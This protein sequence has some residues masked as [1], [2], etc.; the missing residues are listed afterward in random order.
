MWW[1]S[2]NKILI[3]L[4]RISVVKVKKKKKIVIKN[5][6]RC[7]R[8]YSK[9]AGT[10][11]LEF[12]FTKIIFFKL[13]E[14]KRLSLFLDFELNRVLKKYLGKIVFQPMH[15]H[16]LVSTI[17]WRYTR[18]VWKNTVFKRNVNKILINLCLVVNF[19]CCVN[20]SKCPKLYYFW[21]R[22]SILNH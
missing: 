15:K 22:F 1:F 11:I 6:R 7:I 5:P 18:K 14:N 3:T 2:S 9:Y 10:H 16:A 8:A 20:I 17:I 19:R 12:V 21:I 13:K 4:F